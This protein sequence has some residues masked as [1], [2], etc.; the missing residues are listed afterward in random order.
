MLHYVT[1]TTHILDQV[2]PVPGIIFS[3]FDKIM[4][5]LFWSAHCQQ[6]CKLNAT[7]YGNRTNHFCHL[8]NCNYCDRNRLLR[9]KEKTWKINRVV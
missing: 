2:Q 8:N 5:N 4:Q 3:L 6:S 7:Y 9:Q 1:L